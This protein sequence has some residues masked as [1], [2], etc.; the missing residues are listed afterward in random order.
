MNLS[1]D[2]DNRLTDFR[3]DWHLINTRSLISATEHADISHTLPRPA[4]SRQ[5]SDDVIPCNL[6][7]ND[8]GAEPVSL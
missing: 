5:D 4:G 2:V 7:A 6:K 1:F 3:A 8:Y